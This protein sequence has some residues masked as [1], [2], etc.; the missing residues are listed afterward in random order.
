MRK[1]EIAAGSGHRRLQHARASQSAA[2]NGSW[3]WAAY[4]PTYNLLAVDAAIFHED[5]GPTA[6]STGRRSCLASGPFSLNFVGR[7]A[8]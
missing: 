6:A 7:L 1:G 2:S 8:S 4:F 5:V 3:A